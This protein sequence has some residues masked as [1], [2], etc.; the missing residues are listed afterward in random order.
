VVHT[1]GGRVG[2]ILLR[3]RLHE[4]SISL[5][6]NRAD[7]LDP[8][9]LLV[10]LAGDRFVLREVATRRP[11]LLELNS[12][13]RFDLP[14]TDPAY[15]LLAHFGGTGKVG[16]NW[17]GLSSVAHLPRI[18]CGR[19]IVRPERWRLSADSLATVTK[20]RNPG[21]ELRGRLEGLADR[22]WVGFGGAD[23]L[24]PVDLESA[25]AVRSLVRR[26]RR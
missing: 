26:A 13:H 10:S 11:V 19:V 5:R 20:S 23:R 21:R 9:N 12:A 14:G 1:P 2:N 22:R 16:W 7:T 24:L 4:R 6:G 17:G 15:R 8:A 18:T 25:E 3:P